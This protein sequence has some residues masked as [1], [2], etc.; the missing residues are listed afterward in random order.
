MGQGESDFLRSLATEL[1]RKLPHAETS[2][3]LPRKRLQSE[4]GESSQ[5]T[6]SPRRESTQQQKCRR[7]ASATTQAF[8]SRHSPR[9]VQDRETYVTYCNQAFP[10]ACF[11]HYRTVVLGL[12]GAKLGLR[13]Y[14]AIYQTSLLG[15][16]LG[17]PASRLASQR[18]LRDWGPGR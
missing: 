8:A 5:E 4:N 7:K 2:Q 6:R 3:E 9:V 16:E 14:P 15:R 13:A 17:L 1:P 18:C 12:P 10:W 11:S